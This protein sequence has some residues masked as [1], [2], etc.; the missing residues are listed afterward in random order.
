MSVETGLRF[1]RLDL[2]LLSINESFV[3]LDLL[4]VQSFLLFQ[5]L[6]Q[7]KLSFLLVMA[8]FDLYFERILFINDLLLQVSFLLFQKVSIVG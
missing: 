1:Q 5:F 6:A 7:E 2:F 3:G 4:V 8:L